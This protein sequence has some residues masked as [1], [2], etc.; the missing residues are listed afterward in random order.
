[1]EAK[2]IVK[3][4]EPR[5]E[6]GFPLGDEVL[7]RLRDYWERLRVGD[8]PPRSDGLYL[9]DLTSQMPHLLMCFK[10]GTAFRIEF[11]GSEA[12]DRVGFD[13]T[14]EIL[15]ANDPHPVLAGIAR[16]GASAARG[17]GPV[18]T[19]GDGWMAIQLP[20]VEAP[21]RVSVL[22]IGLVEIIRLPPAEILEFRRR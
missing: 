10:D 20:F 2:M 6:V 16:G 5:D 7:D 18:L 19:H 17:R 9:S 14:G 12:Q 8:G 1:V 11:A 21:G 3:L 13:P 4:P 15:Q 22:L